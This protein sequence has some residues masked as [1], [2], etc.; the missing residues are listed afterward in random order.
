MKWGSE[1]RNETH[2]SRPSLGYLDYSY[3]S[4]DS[5]NTVMLATGSHHPRTS[6]ALALEFDSALRGVGWFAQSD[7]S[8]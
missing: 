4:Q 6:R 7:P 5:N 1:K 3:V 8:S 2:T